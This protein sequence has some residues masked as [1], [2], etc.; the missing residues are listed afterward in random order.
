MDL[1]KAFYTFPHNRLLCK[2]ENNVIRGDAVNWV[3]AFLENGQQCVVVN[4]ERSDFVAVLSDVPQGSVIGP[5]LFLTCINDLP[6]NIR[7]KVRPSADDFILY[8][9]ITSED[10]CWQLQVDLDNGRQLG[11]WSLT[12]LSVRCYGFRGIR[13]QSNIRINRTALH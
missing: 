10:H 1:S 12:T 9:T 3:K 7:S 13:P 8:L 4:S 6:Q 5:V 2:L 11:G